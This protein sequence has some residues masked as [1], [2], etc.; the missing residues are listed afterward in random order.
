[1]FEAIMPNDQARPYQIVL[2]DGKFDTENGAGPAGLAAIF[3]ALRRDRPERLV[4]HFHGGLISREAGQAAAEVLAP[5]YGGAGA[6]PI[7]VIWES[8]WL[9][10]V[11]QQLAA[12][13]NEGIFQRIQRRVTQFVRGKLDKEMG[14]GG[15]RGPGAELPMP[16]Q[17]TIDDEIEKGRAGQPIFTDLPLDQLPPNVVPTPDDTGLSP[18]ERQQ[19]Q[20]EIES[21]YALQQNLE[22]IAAG[23]QPVT[24]G[25]ARSAGTAAPTL[26]EPSVLDEI[27]PIPAPGQA[28]RSVIS[29]FMVA[30]HIARAVGGIVWRVANSRGHGVY[31]TIIEEILRE[32]YVGAAGKFLWDG[33]KTEI[34]NAFTAAPDRGGAALVKGLRT[35]WQDDFKPKVTLVGHSAGAIYVARL[36]CELNDKMPEDFAVEIVLIAP[37]CTFTTLAD[38]LQTAGK[39]VQGMRIFGMGDGTERQDALVPLLY[40]ASLL[41]FVAGVLEEESDSPLVG[42]ARYYQAPYTGGK[43]AAVEAVKAFELLKR[44]HA[45]AWSQISGFDGAN[46]D[47]TSH[48]GWVHAAN[49]RDSVMHIIEKGYG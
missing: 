15:S 6:A 24:S 28:P 27:A 35:A 39:R 29:T 46:C 7:F 3:E 31:L 23:R 37:A 2:N 26:M 16:M 12:I 20:E 14:P 47:M 48:G 38:A 40:P 30:R 33:M 1:L 18:T 4:I 5:Y 25:T 44:Q 19:I 45:F 43:F 13:F 9:E 41:Y 17:S 10:V 11:K 21:D 8:G 42:M 22:A 36:L 49:T 32:F 34:D